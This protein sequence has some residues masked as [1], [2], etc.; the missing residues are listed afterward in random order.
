[1]PEMMMN[2]TAFNQTKVR[3]D[4]LYLYS[5]YLT[6]KA[7]RIHAPLKKPRDWK[8]TVFEIIPSKGISFMNFVFSFRKNILKTVHCY[9]NKFSRLFCKAA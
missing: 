4:Y 3:P 1:M 9:L 7:K 8:K 2:L 6:Q 5:N